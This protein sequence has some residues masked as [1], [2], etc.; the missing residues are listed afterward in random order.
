MVYAGTGGSFFVCLQVLPLAEDTT[1]EVDEDLFKMDE[2]RI[3]VMRARGAGGQV[4][5]LSE[6]LNQLLD[7]EHSTS[8]K[9]SP[10]YG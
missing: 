9:Q 7:F 6:G 4:R 1:L 3:E 10:P 8:T 2:V 5:Q